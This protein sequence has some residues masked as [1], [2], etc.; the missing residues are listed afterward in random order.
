M[1]VGLGELMNA[2]EIKRAEEI[3]LFLEET[4]S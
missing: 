2:N 4:K 3:R 1:K